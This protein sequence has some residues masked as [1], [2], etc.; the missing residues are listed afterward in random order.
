MGNWVVSPYLKELYHSMLYLVFG[1]NREL[2]LFNQILV[3]QTNKPQVRRANTIINDPC[4][5][6]IRPCFGGLIFKTRD[7]LVSRYIL[8]TIMYKA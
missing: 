2:F 1:P 5:D 7:H 3:A 4:F 8:Y 6:W